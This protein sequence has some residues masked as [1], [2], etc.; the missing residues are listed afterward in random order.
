MYY[1]HFAQ[2][3]SNK[4]NGSGKNK[5]AQKKGSEK[6]EELQTETLAN[7]ASKVAFSNYHLTCNI[8]QNGWQCYVVKLIDFGNKCYVFK[9]WS[10]WTDR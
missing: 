2:V 4:S 3:D 1:V 7:L 10:N 8:L 5:A 6:T 9:S